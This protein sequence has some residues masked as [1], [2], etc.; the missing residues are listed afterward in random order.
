MDYTLELYRIDRRFRE[1]ERLVL[2]QD[3]LATEREEIL[4]QYQG[5]GNHRAVIRET[6]VQR[7]NYVTGETYSER[8]DTP[9]AC[10]P[11]SEAYWSM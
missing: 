4:R 1:G 7:Q 6:W 8:Y 5:L 10:S 9:N 3:F 11:S 2:K